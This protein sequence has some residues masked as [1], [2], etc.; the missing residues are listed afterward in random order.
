VVCTCPEC[1]LNLCAKC[2]ASVH[3]KGNRSAHARNY[4]AAAGGGGGDDDELTA[5]Y[6]EQQPLPDSVG[7]CE[8]CDAPHKDIIGWCDECELHLCAKCD[9][10][11]HS[12]G[13][14]TKHART[15]F[16]G[17]KPLPPLVIEADPTPPPEEYTPPVE[18][19]AV[20]PRAVSPTGRAAASPS[21]VTSPGKQRPG[22]ERVTSQGDDDDDEAKEAEAKRLRAMAAA[23]A[24]KPK[25]IAQGWVA[26]TR[27]K[28]PT[29][30]IMVGIEEKKLALTGFGTGVG[31]FV[32]QLDEEKVQFG[33]MRIVCVD[34]KQQN[35]IGKKVAGQIKYAGITFI[36]RKVPTMTKFKV[37]S[38]FKQM[39][40]SLGL[41]VT[42]EYTEKSDI[43]IQG[44]GKLL[45]QAGLKPTLF[46]FGKAGKHE[47]IQLSAIH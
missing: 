34:S 20:S 14:R 44:I 11:V 12:K 17:C 32:K 1:E 29:S 46:D 6:K 10:K 4:F 26:V 19:R 47:E 45:I 15:F 25:T 18:E 43:S 3:S 27:E 39:A 33:V 16:K 23:E 28:D 42:H 37:S 21:S 8:Q 36:G 2:D 24:S 35:N 22:L 31:D 9:Q 7:D 41:T 5:R 38:K 40:S 30:F 13:T